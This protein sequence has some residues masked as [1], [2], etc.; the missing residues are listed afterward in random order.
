MP[1]ELTLA[2][3]ESSSLFIFAWTAP[4]TSVHWIVPVFAELLFGCSMLCLFTSFIP[5]IIECYCEQ[6]WAP[7]LAFVES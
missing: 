3:R 4:F 7:V 6:D 5:Y 2:A 1:M